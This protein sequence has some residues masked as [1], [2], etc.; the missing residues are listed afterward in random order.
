MRHTKDCE[1][2]ACLVWLHNE[3]FRGPVMTSAAVTQESAGGTKET[4]GKLDWSLVPFDAMEEVVRVL[5]FGVKKYARDNWKQ[6]I[7]DV[8][9][10]LF[11]AMHRHLT[12]YSKGEQCAEDSQLMHMAHVACNA[13]F[14]IWYT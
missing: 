12:A 9:N 3:S 6:D 11:A 13:L 8:K 10:K 7:P 4:T 5:E 1:C 14:L 2:T